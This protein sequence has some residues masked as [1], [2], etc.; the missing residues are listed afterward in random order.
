MTVSLATGKALEALNLD[1]EFVLAARYW[2]ARLKLFI[3]DD[4]YFVDIVD[5]VI[6]RFVEGA[7]GFDSYTIVIGGPLDV[8]EQILKEVPP[9]FYQDFWSAFMRHGFTMTGDLES[10]YAYY[11]ALRRM[12]EVLRSI[13]NGEA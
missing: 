5:G 9:P 1:P 11:G 4:A 8:W 3:G 2:N 7:N 6:T 10:L 13:H 12:V